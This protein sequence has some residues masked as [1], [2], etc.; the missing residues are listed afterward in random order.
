MGMAQW[1]AST[2]GSEYLTCMVPRTGA[3]DHVADA[4]A[5]GGAFQLT[6]V[7]M[8]AQHGIITGRTL[9]TRP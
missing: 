8:V 9:E 5:P 7:M 4:L 3:C 6:W 2:L 1:Y